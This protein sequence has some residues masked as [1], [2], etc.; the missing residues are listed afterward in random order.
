M[1]DQMVFKEVIKQHFALFQSLKHFCT[2]QG[3]RVYE[4]FW[5]TLG[6]SIKSNPV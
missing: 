1:R 4:Q 3:V 5:C 6:I 2:K